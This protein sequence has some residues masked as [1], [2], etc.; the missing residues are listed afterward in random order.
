MPRRRQIDDR[1]APVLLQNRHR[2]PAA[3]IGCVQIDGQR[4]APIVRLHVLHIGG[5][6]GDAGVVDHNVEAAEAAQRFVEQ[7]VDLSRIGDVGH[8]DSHGRLR[9]LECLQ[10]GLVDIADMD[11]GAGREEGLGGD[12]ADAGRG[13]GDDDSF[14]FKVSAMASP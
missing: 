3:Q 11:P 4:A 2:A 12:P 7:P 6:S 8:R 9:R 1:A 14:V 5:R 13:S 10:P